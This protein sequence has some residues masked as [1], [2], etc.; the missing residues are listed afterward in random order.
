MIL[1]LF[2]FVPGCGGEGAKLPELADL[3]ARPCAIAL[4]AQPGDGSLDKR[5]AEVQ[6]EVRKA[7]NP[8]P[9][10]E[11]LGSLYVA[12][13]RRTFDPGFY[14]LAEQCALCMESVQP[15]SH[16]AM[17]LRGHVLQSMHRFAEAETLARELTAKRGSV[18]DFGLLG[19]ALV[20]QGR[21][22]EAADAY[23]KM[24]D[25]RPFLQSYARAAHVRWLKGD[26]AG[27][28]KLA[29]LA[30]TAGSPRDAESVAWAQTA[31]ASYRLQAGR[32]DDALAACDAALALE[33][34]YPKAL[35]LKGRAL[36]AKDDAA[37]ALP[38]L[39]LA[40]TQNP[41]PEPQWLLADALRCLGR[42]AEAS[43]VESR[44]SSTGEAGDPRTFSLYL[45]TR[46]ERTADALRL[47]EG[48]LASRGDV[49]TLDAMAWALLAAGRAADA[50]A[51]MAKALAE[52]TA[53]ARLFLHAGVIAASAGDRE[54][55]LAS[56]RKAAEQKQML[57]PS[58]RRLLEKHTSAL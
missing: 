46:G 37:Q 35:S 44:L 3:S 24:V 8:V 42:E 27:A 7:H 13:A 33:K 45:A 43:S 11:R 50:R 23:Q 57:F 54:G 20:D 19:D 4:A 39:R 28:T 17:L 18:Y 34:D 25:L 14:K 52:G 48:E 38:L 49:F 47:A 26:L 6:G 55:A 30:V 2:G 36:L 5:V 56:L 31:L 9:K 51:H 22:T 53:D 21:I 40:A 32:I 12:K 58:E 10:L 1:L 29:E 16:D 15:G 41:E